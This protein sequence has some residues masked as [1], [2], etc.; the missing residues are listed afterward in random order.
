[1]ILS[2]GLSHCY[3][4][5]N[6][7][8]VILNVFSLTCLV[9]DVSCWLSP[10]LGWSARTPTTDFCCWPGFPHSTAAGF[11]ESLG[12]KGWLSLGNHGAH[13]CHVLF[14]RGES[15]RLHIFKDRGI[16][17]QLLKEGLLVHPLDPNY[18][19]SSHMQNIVTYFYSTSSH[20]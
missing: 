13:P 14:I 20:L 9:V 2:Q 5:V 17:L 7:A 12:A 15:L 10:K 11:Q 8:G 1:M 19:H 16:R 18:L 6:V 4:I 3:Q